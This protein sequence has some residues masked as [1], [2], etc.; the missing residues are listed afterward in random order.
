[1]TMRPLHLTL[2][3]ANIATAGFATGLTGAGPWTSTSFTRVAA[4]DSLAHLLTLTSTANLSAITI[5]IVGTDPDGIAQTEAVAGPNI[6][7][8]TLTKYFA[9]ITSITAS[10]TLGANTLDVGWAGSFTTQ[11]LPT[12]VYLQGGYYSVEFEV[13]G[14]IGFDLEVTN[15]DIR[16]EPQGLQS[17]YVWLNDANFTAKTASL[18]ANTAVAPYRAVRVMVN[19]Y[20]NGAALVFNLLT[21]K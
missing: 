10:A 4:T 14:T 21:P 13:T 15:S 7:T 12:E 17:S 1:M 6:N 19:S 8:I 11:T 3:P 9:T 16:R 20:S 2:A 5:T 18:I